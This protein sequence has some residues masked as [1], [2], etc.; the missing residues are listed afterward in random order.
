MSR[1]YRKKRAYCS[2]EDIEV[3]KSSI[4]KSTLENKVAKDYLQSCIYEPKGSQVS[5]TVPHV[6]NPDFVHPNQPDILLEVKGY[7]IKGSADCQKYLAIIRDNPDKE[8]VFIFSDPSKRAYAG[9]RI[10]KDGSYL[11]LGEWCF[12]NKILFF[13]VEEIPSAISNGEWS[14]EDVR[15]YK[16]GLYETV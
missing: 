12:K 15:E 8:L 14:L 3:R 6:Y 5:Y 9:C 11:S 2:K 13:K 10:R 16:R 4:Y 7:M 1:T